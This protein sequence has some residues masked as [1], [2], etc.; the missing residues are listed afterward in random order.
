MID[1]IIYGFYQ[2]FINGGIDIKRNLEK[3]GYNLEDIGVFIVAYNIVMTTTPV[4]KELSL[5]KMDFTATIK[6]YDELIHKLENKKIIFLYS[7][8][9]ATLRAEL[10]LPAEYFINKDINLLSIWGDYG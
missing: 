2:K 4:I 8:D 5:D 10:S 9:L 1:S 3:L 7:D 6:N